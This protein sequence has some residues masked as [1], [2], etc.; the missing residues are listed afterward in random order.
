[1]SHLINIIQQGKLIRMIQMP[2]LESLYITPRTFSVHYTIIE[3]T[4]L[5]PV[6]YFQGQ[7]SRTFYCMFALEQIKLLSNWSV[8]EL[9][10]QCWC[11]EI[12]L[13]I[14]Y[15]WYASCFITHCLLG[16]HPVYIALRYRFI[17]SRMYVFK[18]WLFLRAD[19]LVLFYSEVKSQ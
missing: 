19:P 12:L 18:L 3:H 15:T 2:E 17:Q 10:C 7:V 8:R 9:W 1:M 5:K 14:I 4:A 6:W 16:T 11:I 13:Y